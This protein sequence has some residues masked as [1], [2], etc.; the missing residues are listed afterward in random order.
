[1]FEQSQVRTRSSAAANILELI[2]HSIVRNVRKTHSNAL[3][4][5][6]M[7]MVQAVMFVAAFYVMF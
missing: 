4:G 5:L 7:N 3:I 6:L 2:Y 1:M